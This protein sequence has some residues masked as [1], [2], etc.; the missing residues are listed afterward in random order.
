MWV[1]CG[2]RWLHREDEGGRL[3]LPN[4]EM[5]LGP[6]CATQQGVPWGLVGERERGWEQMDAG[7]G[8][9]NETQFPAAETRAGGSLEQPHPSTP[10][11]PRGGGSEETE[12]CGPQA[13]PVY[14]ERAHALWLNEATA[15]PVDQG[16]AQGC[17]AREGRAKSTGCPRGSPPGRAEPEARSPSW[18]PLSH[19]CVP[20]AW[21]LPCG[22]RGLSRGHPPRG[23]GASILRPLREPRPCT[24]DAQQGTGAQG[25]WVGSRAWPRDPPHQG[26]W[27]GAAP[28]ATSGL[29]GFT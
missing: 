4:R 17:G 16:S 12:A 9:R 29:P 1:L 23:H 18:V 20:Q 19:T 2:A 26:G 13:G 15:V 11:T 8:L 22:R 10:L 21:E 27:G 25:S 14:S 7:Q 5:V 3:S 24:S 6:E 28:T